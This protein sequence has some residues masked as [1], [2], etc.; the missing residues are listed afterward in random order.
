MGSFRM[1][2]IVYVWLHFSRA[3]IGCLTAARYS[4]T[5]IGHALSIRVGRCTGAFKS[6]SLVCNGLG[7]GANLC[8]LLQVVHSSYPLMMASHFAGGLLDPVANSALIGATHA[9]IDANMNSLDTQ[10]SSL[11]STRSPAGE[12]LVVLLTGILAVAVAALVGVIGPCVLFLCYGFI[13]LIRLVLIAIFPAACTAASDR[14]RYT[15]RQQ[16]LRSIPDRW[17]SH[18][19]VIIWGV[20]SALVE[21]FFHVYLLELDAPVILVGVTVAVGQ[22]PETPL[23]Q[24]FRAAVARRAECLGAGNV[25]LCRLALAARCFLYAMLP[26]MGVWLVLLLEPLRFV[27]CHMDA[28]PAGAALALGSL[29]WGSALGRVALAPSFRLAGALLLGW[30]FIWSLRLVSL[31]LTRCWHSRRFSLPESLQR[32]GE[33]DA[34]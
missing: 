23:L 12:T 6:A 5:L 16:R 27:D 17:F 25:V 13:A 2:G 31:R 3:Q 21:A 28:L 30:S 24:D 18:I 4:A 22:V 1:I 29:F 32:H 15:S 26:D 20:C 19:D 8:P 34:E 10:T 33:I 9:Q 7:I 14:N 11:S